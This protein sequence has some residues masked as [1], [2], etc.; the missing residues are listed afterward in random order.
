MLPAALLVASGLAL[1]DVSIFI[2][3]KLSGASRV[4]V[5]GFAE[6]VAFQFTGDR[7]RSCRFLFVGA[8]SLADSPFTAVMQWLG[9]L[10]HRL[11]G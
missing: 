4:Q 1:Q 2:S 3:C 6:P 9:R 5:D 11:P 10:L 8:R 7:D